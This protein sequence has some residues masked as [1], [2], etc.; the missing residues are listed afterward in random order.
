MGK[1]LMLFTFSLLI[2]VVLA[3]G[4]V[5]AATEPPKEDIAITAEGATRPLQVK[6]SHDKHKAYKCTDCHHVYKPN[7]KGEYEKDKRGNY[8]TLPVNDWKDDQKVEKCSSCH[9]L[10]ADKKKK[11][12]MLSSKTEARSMEDAFHDN[13]VACH[14]DYNKEKKLKGKDG[15]PSRCNDC[16]EKSK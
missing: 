9:K 14:K 12:E 6:F 2:V 5:F 4:T 10:E 7:D 16:H 15:L 3:A 1:R 13:C 11:K 8:K